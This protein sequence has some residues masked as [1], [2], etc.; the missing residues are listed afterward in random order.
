M[1]D[2]LDVKQK[3]FDDAWMSVEDAAPAQ[4]DV[5]VRNLGWHFM[6]MALACSRFGLGRT[7][8]YAARNAI[9]RALSQTEAKY[10][11]AELELVQISRYLGLRVAKATLHTRHIQHGATL[12]VKDELTDR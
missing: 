1:P 9:G 5:A 11:A 10:N 8:E 7:D 3:P 4:L 6:W 2:G 12:G